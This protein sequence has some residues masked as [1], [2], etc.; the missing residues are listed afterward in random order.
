[1]SFTES[2]DGTISVAC[3]RFFS[4]EVTIFWWVA[5][6]SN[7]DSGIFSPRHCRYANDPILSKSSHRFYREP[8][9]VSFPLRL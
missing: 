8:Y 4:A 9:E 7:P 2:T 5:G 6:E 1:M 3:R